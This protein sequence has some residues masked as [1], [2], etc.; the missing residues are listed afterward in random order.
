MAGCADPNAPSSETPSTTDTS[1]AGSAEAAVGSALPV[2]ATAPL[3]EL[4]NASGGTIRL[5]EQLEQGPVVL[6]FYRGAWCPYC[7]TQLRDYQQALDSIGATGASLLAIS[8]QI[9]DS[10][11][12]I[13]EKQNLSFPVLSDVGN[14]VSRDYGLVFQVD[15]ATRERYRAVGIDLTAS[16]GDDSWELPVPAVYVIGQDGTVQSAFVEADYTQRASTDQ[17]LN[18]LQAL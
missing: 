11:L 14:Q 1:V 3:F 15:E 12:T 9:P 16:N 10:S 18:A 17:I 4:P 5:A 13:Q 7:N 6:V 2:G 8:P